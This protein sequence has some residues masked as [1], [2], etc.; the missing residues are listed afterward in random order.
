MVHFNVLEACHKS[1]VDNFVFASSAAVYGDV[2]KLPI[3]EN[4]VIKTIISL[5]YKQDACRT[6]CLVIQKSKKIKNTISLRI[7][8]VYGNG[9][10]SEADV[11]TRFA[12]RLSNG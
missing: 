9:Q 2:K 1:G 10:T 4:R 6:T 8:N 7:F 11:I 5:W 12:K 3:S